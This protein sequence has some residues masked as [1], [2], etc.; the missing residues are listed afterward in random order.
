MKKH[1]DIWDEHLR[2]ILSK[3]HEMIANWLEGEA[4]PSS[5]YHLS[6]NL[7]IS[8]WVVDQI[9]Y[10]VPQFR[11]SFRGKVP[12]AMDLIRIQEASKFEPTYN[13]SN[14]V[15][16]AIKPGIH[17]QKTAVRLQSFKDQTWFFDQVSAENRRA[18]LRQ[19]QQDI[20]DKLSAGT[21]IPC[22]RCG[23]IIERGKEWK[24]KV[25]GTS[26]SGQLYSIE[27]NFCS[28]FCGETEQINAMR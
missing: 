1:I 18:V 4:A 20:A 14:I 6:H 8:R 19:E 7:T 16:T 22:D 28:L 17:Q 11:V 13:E 12:T 24:M 10:D 23:K 2:V 3:Q 15:I 27:M 9:K 26:N 5:I 25:A 21:H